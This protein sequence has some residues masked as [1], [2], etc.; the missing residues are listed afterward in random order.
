MNAAVAET[1]HTAASGDTLA[2]WIAPGRTA[3]VVIDIQ[4][5]FAAP[6]KGHLPELLEGIHAVLNVVHGVLPEK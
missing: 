5:D 2:D 4:V 3:V 6:I 1:S